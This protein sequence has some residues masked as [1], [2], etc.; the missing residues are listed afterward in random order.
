[1]NFIELQ[2]SLQKLITGRKIRQ[3]DIARAL[4]TSTSNL[5]QKFNNPNS[6]VSVAELLKVQDYFGVK[7]FIK[8]DEVINISSQLAEYKT[9]GQ[10]L[11]YL[12]AQNNLT[13]DALAKELDIPE[14]YI[15]KL[16]LDKIEPD[17]KILRKL[18]E[19]F[20]V[21]IDLLL[22]GENTYTENDK[23]NPEELKILEV[24]QKAKRNKLI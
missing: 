11:N 19:Y 15:E 9:F 20:N 17:L 16:G 24:I 1:M 7:I 18:R 2:E 22:D 13:V 8:Q 12:M 14:S 21:S 5:S 23:L 10:R 4:E 6:E 3:A